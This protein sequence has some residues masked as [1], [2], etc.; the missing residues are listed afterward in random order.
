MIKAVL[1]RGCRSE[2]AEHLGYDKGDPAGRG[3]PNMRSG[4]TLQDDPVRAGPAGSP[5]SRGTGR[6]ASTRGWSRRAP[7]GSAAAWTR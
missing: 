4:S 6:G 7:V 1:K 3:S 2:L 5:T